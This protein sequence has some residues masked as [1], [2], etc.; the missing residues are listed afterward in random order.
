MLAEHSTLTKQMVKRV[1][2]VLVCTWV[3]KPSKKF[4]K[5]ALDH[6]HR[7][8]QDISEFTTPS[9]IVPSVLDAEKYNL[10]KECE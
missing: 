7:D 5:T 6:F 4:T 1:E 8:F 9:R 2:T 10:D 3:Y